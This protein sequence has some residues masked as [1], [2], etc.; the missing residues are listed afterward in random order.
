MAGIKIGQSA[1]CFEV[2]NILSFTLKTFYKLATMAHKVASYGSWSVFRI[3]PFLCVL[4]IPTL[5]H[6]TTVLKLPATVWKAASYGSLSLFRIS[7]YCIFL[8]IPTSKYKSTRLKLPANVWKAASYGF[9]LCFFTSCFTCK[10]FSYINPYQS[11]RI[12]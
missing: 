4:L 2:R 5:R 3:H 11:H 1:W 8:L 7:P 6:K 9:H 10:G 12:E